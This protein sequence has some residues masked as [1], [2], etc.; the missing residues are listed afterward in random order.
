MQWLASICV[1]PPVFATVLILI[2]A[3]V[4][5]VGYIKLSVD[6]FPKVDFP[7]VAVVTALPGRR[8]AGDRDRGHRQDRRGGQHHQRHRGA[9]LDLHR[10]RLAGRSS[11]SVSTRTST[12]PR[13]RCATT[14]RRC[15]PTCPRGRR[16]RSITKLDP[17]AAP[18]LFIALRVDA[19]DPRGHR[20]RRPRGPAGAGERPGRRPGDDRRRPQAPDPRG[21]RPGASCGRRG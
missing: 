16:A 20:V 14:C 2:I 11:A 9:A 15:C 1:K 8:P 3:V 10:G 17:D 19:P 6:R 21:A 12:S 7:I 18:V 13:R 5:V 4:G